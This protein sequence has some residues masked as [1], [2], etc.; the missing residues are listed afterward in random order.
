MLDVVQRNFP[1]ADFVA[2]AGKRILQLPDAFGGIAG[3]NP[4]EHECVVNIHQRTRFFTALRGVTDLVGELF[5]IIVQRREIGLVPL[6]RGVVY[7]SLVVHVFFQQPIVFIV[8]NTGANIDIFAGLILLRSCNQR[9]KR[10]SKDQEKNPKFVHKFSSSA[11]YS[12]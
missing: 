5:Q 9:E 7:Q 6:P 4:A 11:N 8:T 3:Q 10:K 2:L 12:R 1:A